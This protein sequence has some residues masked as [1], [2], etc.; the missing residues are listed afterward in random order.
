MFKK[1][2]LFFTCFFAPF[3]AC[4]ACSQCEPKEKSYVQLED[5][6]F[7]QTGIWLNDKTQQQLVGIKAV[8]SDTHGFYVEKN[9]DQSWVCP[10]CG[11]VNVGSPYGWG[12]VKCSWPYND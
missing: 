7:D 5:L 10:H 8:R 11:K 4:G 6:I 9:E 1:M 2:I 12:C 3:V